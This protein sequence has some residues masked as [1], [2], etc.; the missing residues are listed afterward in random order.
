MR[1]LHADDAA[2]KDASGSGQEIAPELVLAIAQTNHAG[3]QEQSSF[4]FQHIAQNIANN[5]TVHISS[6]FYARIS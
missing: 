6:R 2:Q 5:R 1:L 3:Q 4:D